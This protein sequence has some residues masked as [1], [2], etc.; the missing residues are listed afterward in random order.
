MPA[1]AGMERWRAP[2]GTVA[3]VP[4]STARSSTWSLRG[5]TSGDD[6][7]SSRRLPPEQRKASFAATHALRAAWATGCIGRRGWYA[8]AVFSRAPRASRGARAAVPGRPIAPV[9]APRRDQSPAGADPAEA[10]AAAGA[11]RMSSDEAECAVC[12]EPTRHRLHPCAHVVCEPCARQWR[13]HSSACPLC[14]GLVVPL[15]GGVAATPRPTK[16]A[17]LVLTVDFPPGSHGGVTL[18]NSAWFPRAVYVRRMHRPDQCA[19]C[20]LR[21]GDYVLA[22]DGV[23][24]PT[25]E[26]GVRLIDHAA[27]AQRSVRVHVRRFQWRS[28]RGEARDEVV[29]RRLVE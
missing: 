15:D 27:S 2:T 29:W 17:N 25:H 18:Q 24:V 22:I 19:A 28:P 1:R 20:G 3:A 14:R 11:A 8:A 26:V 16:Y 7:A 10:P 13:R 9:V 5:A 6:S 21:R 12:L 4:P 23:A